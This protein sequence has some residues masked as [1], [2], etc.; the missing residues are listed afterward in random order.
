[1]SNAWVVIILGNIILLAGFI[2]GNGHMIVG[3]AVFATIGVFWEVISKN[4]W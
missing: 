2:L 4:L 1:M 3:G